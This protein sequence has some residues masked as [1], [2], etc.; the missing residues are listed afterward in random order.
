M[1]GIIDNVKNGKSIRSILTS[2]E[3]EI[4][5]EKINECKLNCHLVVSCYYQEESS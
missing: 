1:V 2:P 4:H 3:A 5:V